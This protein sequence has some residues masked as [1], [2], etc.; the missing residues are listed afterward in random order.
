MRW[1]FLSL[2]LAFSLPVAGAAKD[3]AAA[4]PRFHVSESA[5]LLSRD[6]ETV[7]I[8]GKADKTR[9]SSSSGHHF[10]NFTGSDFSVICRAEHLSAFT[11]EGPARIYDQKLIEIRGPLRIYKGKPQISLE[12]PTQIRDLSPAKPEE[13]PFKLRPAGHDTWTS[14]GGLVFKGRDPRGLTRLEHIMRHAKD[15][16]DRQGSHGV[17]DGDAKTIFML[18]DEA[19][20]VAR[21][22]G[23]RPKVESD[24]VAY[25]I[26]MGRRVGYLGGEAGARENHPPL[27]SVFMV[28]HRGTREVITAFPH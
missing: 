15:I 4:I 22:R 8:Y 10:L 24:R 18:L 11:G 3:Q 14:P 28:F 2:L 16:P 27:R 23:I 1:L 9:V 19:W 21:R 12:S 6:G 7:T 25:T 13:K 17:F 5:K 20:A 26:P